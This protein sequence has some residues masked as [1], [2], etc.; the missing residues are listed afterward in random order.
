LRLRDLQQT[1]HDLGKLDPL[2]AI[3]SAPDKRGNRWDL[4]E[5]FALGE[6]EI[7]DRLQRAARWGLPG[8]REALDFGCGVGRLTQAMCG[9]FERAAGVDIA[10]SMIKQARRYNRHG[11]RCQYHLNAADHLG[12]FAPDRFDFVYSIIV[13]QHMP[14]HLAMGY[15]REFVRV[16][17]PGGLLMVQ[18]PSHLT[19][20]GEEQQRASAAA[21]ASMAPPPSR[22]RRLR[23]AVG[24]RVKPLLGIPTRQP[25]ISMYGT[26][27][28]TVVGVLT[29]AGAKV[30]E[31]E[32]NTDAGPEW[33]SFGYWVTK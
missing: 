32:P 6:Q 7:A 9:H 4:R 29:E 22:L 30:L 27:R 33:F 18:L 17:A 20:L 31:V 5:F 11:D 26:P 25:F 10:P 14:S 1:W 28:D 8:R 19:P 13:L 24:R 23:S 3:L 15:L 12:L 2:W 16:L 21:P